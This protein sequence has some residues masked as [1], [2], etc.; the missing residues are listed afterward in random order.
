M[1]SKLFSRHIF[2]IFAPKKDTNFF[3]SRVPRPGDIG[4]YGDSV[5]F[6]KLKRK[7]YSDSERKKK[8][9]NEKKKKK[10]NFIF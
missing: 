2:D 1:I 9:V 8:N 7:K 3:F 4:G 10:K 6:F 5:L